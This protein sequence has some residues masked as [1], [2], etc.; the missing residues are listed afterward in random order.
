MQCRISKKNKQLA[1]DLVNAMNRADTLWLLDDYAD[2]LLVWTTGNT[3]IAGK[4][5]DKLTHLDQ[6]N[7]E[8]IDQATVL[9]HSPNALILR[10]R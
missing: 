2:D 4:G 1:R 8:G 9:L 3:V 5:S 7:N 10:F 6:S